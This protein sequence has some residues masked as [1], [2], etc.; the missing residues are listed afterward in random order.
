VLNI[1]GDVKDQNVVIVD[2]LIS[3][4]G[5]LV[6][7]A[8]AL[9][10]QGALDIYACI[11][12]PVLAGPAIER[13]NGSCIKELIVSDSIPVDEAATEGKVKVLSVAPI[14]SEAIKRIHQNESVSSLFANA[15][16]EA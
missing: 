1:I 2:D 9:K 15:S 14:L 8:A 10:E 16:V 13:I 4:G 11:V 3:T 5:S 12:H 6:E 7:A